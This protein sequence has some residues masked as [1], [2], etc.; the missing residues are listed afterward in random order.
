[1]SA[2]DLGCG[3]GQVAMI[4]AERGYLVSGVD[5][6]ETAVQLGELNAQQAGLAIWFSV[7]D[8]LNLDGFES[9]TMD[10]IV[11][12]HVL[13]CVIGA[14]DRLAFLR[15]AYR[16]LKPGGILFSETM[17]CEGDFDAVAMEADPA[18]RTASSHT[19]YWVSQRELNGEIEA[20]GFRVVHQELRGQAEPAGAQIITYA[21]RPVPRE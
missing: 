6:S 9:E 8:C 11:D 1:V 17:S 4:L 7:G 3:G 5:Y 15:S 16:V 2:L 20:T 13:H 14:Q 10:L 18:T 21:E 19:R 12:N